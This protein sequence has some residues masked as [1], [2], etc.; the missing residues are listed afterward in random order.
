MKD[1]FN[2]IVQ[3]SMEV[4]EKDV[5]KAQ[6]KFKEFWDTCGLEACELKTGVFVKYE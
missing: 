6:D 1:R 5:R 3:F 2:R 4:Q